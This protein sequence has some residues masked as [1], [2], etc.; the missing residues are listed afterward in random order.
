MLGRVSLLYCKK[1]VPTGKCFKNDFVILPEARTVNGLRQRR[2]V[3]ECFK[4]F[5]H[6][7]IFCRDGIYLIEKR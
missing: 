1:N 5:W 2:N 3:Q 6:R 4:V 7:L